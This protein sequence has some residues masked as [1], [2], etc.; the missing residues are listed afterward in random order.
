MTPEAERTPAARDRRRSDGELVR[1]HDHAQALRAAYLR[2]PSYNCSP[3]AITA[4]DTA[5]TNGLRRFV[6]DVGWP[7]AELHG[8][9]V[10]DAALVIALRSDRDPVL[11][12]RCRDLLRHAVSSKMDAAYRWAFLVDR[13]AAGHAEPQT[14]GT[15]VRW[16]DGKLLVH[17]IAAPGRL[18]GRRHSVGLG[19][20]A[21]YV[22][23]VAQFAA[24]AR[25]D[26][27]LLPGRPRS[28]S[29]DPFPVTGLGKDSSPSSAHR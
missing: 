29:A 2:R 18:D 21:D 19:P 17:P 5:A 16:R 25:E 11:Q 7:W 10:A 8:D 13:C 4:A 12:L 1:L 3:A 9:E 14:F 27:L 15:R 20:H 24:A 6:A 28:G 23:E 22:R 26:P